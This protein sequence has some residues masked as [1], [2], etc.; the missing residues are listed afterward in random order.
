MI[1]Y[2]LGEAFRSG[3]HKAMI[4]SYLEH[5]GWYEYKG[6]VYGYTRSFSLIGS[7]LSA[8]LSI[9]F[10]LKF[11]VLK[12]VFVASTVPF[13]LDF[14]LIASYPQSL[15]E[16][17]ESQFDFKTFLKVGKEQLKMIGKSVAI[18][19]IVISGASYI[20]VFK[21][22]KDYIQPILSIMLISSGVGLIGDFNQ[23]D[24][25]KIYLGIIYGI[26]YIFSSLASKNIYRVSAKYG[27]YKVF[28]AFYD[29][30]G[31]VF[32]IL[33][34]TIKNHFLMITVVLYFAL[35]VM[36]DARR[37]AFIAV[38]SNYMEKSQRVTVMSL[39]NQ[40]RSLLIVFFG[41]LFGYI[42][43]TFSLSWLFVSIG[44]LLLISNRFFK[45]E[46]E[47]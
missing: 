41:P 1:F 42:A 36:Q 13:I 47:G 29:L 34:L 35:Y 27:D 45:L 9:L 3:T 18:R 6:F 22:I 2:G 46:S 12:W 16:Q 33:A 26:F 38:L 5:K 31:V 8:F 10:V 32:I 44:V 28:S 43:E 23:S 39:E 7:S 21:T 30:M 17:R 14:I 15:N 40:L 20:G 4:L 11:P 37:P 25:L 19:K 24:S